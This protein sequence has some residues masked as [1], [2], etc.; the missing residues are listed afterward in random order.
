MNLTDT[1]DLPYPDCEDPGDGALDLQIL[2]EAIDAKLSASF[3]GFRVIANRPAFYVNLS[4]NVGGY[5]AGSYASIPFD[6]VLFNS[7]DTSGVS[8]S[9]TIYETG[10]WIIGGYLLSNPA[11]GV[12]AN[13]NVSAWLTW[14]GDLVAPLGG[15]Y[16]ETWRTVN[17]QSSTG[18]E[19]QCA[20]G[21]VRQEYDGTA[22]H[23]GGGTVALGIS[24]QNVASTVTVAATTSMWAFKVSDLEDQ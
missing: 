15:S 16:T 11:A 10:Y 19:Y 17:W 13:S 4:T 9:M 12:T 3:A 1:Q 2:A 20:T 7:A 24:H 5:T 8:S 14:R 6:T 21:L 22:D 18:G 23:S